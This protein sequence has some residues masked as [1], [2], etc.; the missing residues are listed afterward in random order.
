MQG[1]APTPDSIKKDL[2]EMLDKYG[3]EFILHL[4]SRLVYEHQWY[5]WN[6]IKA[7]IRSAVNLSL[8]ETKQENSK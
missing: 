8:S 2:I 6:E 4:C 5:N 1:T 3:T 7:D